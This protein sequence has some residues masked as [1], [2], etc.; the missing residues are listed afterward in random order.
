MKSPQGSR[1]LYLTAVGVDC[2]IHWKVALGVGQH[3]KEVDRQMILPTYT[4]WR[5]PSSKKAEKAIVPIAEDAANYILDIA[6]AFAPENG[7][8][9]PLYLPSSKALWLLPLGLG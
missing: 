7:S 8:P 4:L 6:F 5:K 1:P 9:G 2:S 3:V